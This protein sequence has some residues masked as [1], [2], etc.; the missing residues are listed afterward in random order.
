MDP[1]DPDPAP[2]PKPQHRL[3]HSRPIPVY[4]YRYRIT[5]LISAA[6]MTTQGPLRSN[7]RGAHL[8]RTVGIVGVWR[9]ERAAAAAGGQEAISGGRRLTAGR[10]QAQP[11]LQAGVLASQPLVLALKR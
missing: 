10:P 11:H 6:E 9:T 8:P 5:R 2:A 4:S 1:A 3:K 7:Y